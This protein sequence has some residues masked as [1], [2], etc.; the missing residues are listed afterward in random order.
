MVLHGPTK[1]RDLFS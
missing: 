1:L